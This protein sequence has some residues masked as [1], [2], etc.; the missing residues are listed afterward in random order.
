[1]LAE[2]ACRAQ[3][4]RMLTMSSAEEPGRIQIN[5]DLCLHTS[6]SSRAI[7]LGYWDV[8]VN[9]VFEYVQQAGVCDT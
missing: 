6:V 9:G 8:V 7:V 5:G 4:C 1:M 3:L 2:T